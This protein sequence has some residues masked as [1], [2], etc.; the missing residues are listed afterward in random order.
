[1]NLIKEYLFRY[2]KLIFL[3]L[4][5]GTINQVFSLLDPQIFRLIVD[6]YASKVGEIERDAF[7]KGIGLLLVAFVGI[8]LISRIAKNFQDYYVNMISQKVG[9]SIYSDGIDKI[10]KLPYETFEDQRSGETLQKLQKAKL[11]SQNLITQFVNIVFIS[12]VG[13]IFVLIYA[14]IV[15]WLIALSFII[16]IPFLAVIVSLISKKIKTAQT[17]IVKETSNLAGSATETLRNVELVKS[18]G[19]EKQEIE[20]LDKLNNSILS[21][22]LKKTI[23]IRKLSFIQ[24]TLVNGSR[25]ILMFVMLWLIYTAQITLGEFFSLL[26]YSFFLFNPLSEISNVVTAYREARASNDELEKIYSLPKEESNEGKKQIKEINSIEFKNV[27]FNYN[28][29]NTSISDINLK[30]D[31]GKSIAFVGPSG[32]GKTTLIKLL[33]GLY[34]PKKGDIIFNRDSVNSID[35]ESLRK[36]IGLVSQETQLFAG[37]IK[38][39]LIFSNPEASD[40]MCIEALRNASALSIITR[41]GNDGLN[42][43]IGE[44][45][46]KLSGGEK[47]RLAIARALLR[48]PELLI[49]D[50]ATSSLDSITEKQITK[51]I[52]SITNKRKYGITVMIAH[53][54]STILHSDEIYVLERG[55]IVESGTHNSLLKKKGLYYALWR[56]QVGD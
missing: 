36:K 5:L 14:F 37:S 28:S 11:D 8:A 38:D 21:L 26:F 51:T 17:S 23:L 4:L 49:F 30:I 18:L 29:R 35:K 52:Q 54:L 2:K 44:G 43:K 39:N 3:A 56:E 19:L 40:E 1:M 24:G 53:R 55:R 33:V 46:I 9:T 45:G 31:K 7:L 48:N 25:A 15:H 6:N 20:R 42:T 12:L 10:F 50:E 16:L 27:S 47:Q 13:L 32:S 22:E 41:K 34:P